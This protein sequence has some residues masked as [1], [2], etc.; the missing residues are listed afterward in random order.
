[1]H[2]DATVGKP[3]SRQPE[4]LAALI[5]VGL[6]LIIAVARGFSTLWDADGD[7]DSVLRLTQIRDLLGGQSWFDL[8]QYRLGPDGGVVMHWSR[9]VDAPIAALIK[10]AEALGAGPV[11]AENIAITVWP[12]LML[13]ICAW[14]IVR[15]ARLAYGDT[16]IFPAA[17]IGALTLVW[18]GIFTPGRI[19]HHNLQLA[20]SLGLVLGLLSRSFAGGVAAG[21]CAALSMAV[22]METLPFVAFGGATAALL[23]LLHG[24]RETGSA[25]GFGL[26]FAIAGAAC[27]AITVPM[28]AWNAVTCDAYSVAQASAAILAGLGL[29]AISSLPATRRSLPARA[30][31]LAGLG[32]VL[33]VVA[34][35]QFP[36]CLADPYATLDPRLKEFWLDHVNEAQSFFDTLRDTPSR[37]LVWYVTPAIALAVLACRMLR[38]GINR[39]EAVL[40]A[41]LAGAYAISF[42]Q[43]RGAQFAVPLA[44][45]VLA[46]WVARHRTTGR[47]ARANLVSIATWLVSINV[48]W[49]ALGAV[50][51]PDSENAAASGNTANAVK[52]PGSCYAMEDYADLAKLPAGTVLAISNLGSGIITYTHHRALA[53]PYHRNVAGNLAVLDTLLAASEAARAAATRSGATLLAV[54]R[55]NGETSMLAGQAPGSLLAQLA[56]GNVP[57]W[58]QLV[59]GNVDGLEIYRLAP[60]SNP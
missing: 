24:E 11:L 27:F 60:A 16:A 18:I 42:W 35:T 38:N 17:I 22:G 48:A 53:G 14:A 51:T 23:F 45:T 15:I 8:T 50:L 5:T 13:G 37:L 28:S 58:L 19:D 33:G 10:L 49:A 32:G 40:A 21:I 2:S 7:N 9:L 34:L 25:G 6:S 56:K 20:L 55:G 3:A 46:G 36:Q 31:A 54:C 57:D 30:I 1:M 47:S 4:I 12:A 41:L 39:D 52:E 44:V 29:F 43:I 26:G 59:A